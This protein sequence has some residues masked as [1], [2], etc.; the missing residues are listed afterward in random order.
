M[1][2]RT[3][4]LGLGS[5][6]I[7]RSAK[8]VVAPAPSQMQ[9]QRDGPKVPVAQPIGPP[10]AV[11]LAANE[12]VVLPTAQ[13]HRIYLGLGWNNPDNQ[14]SV[15]LDCSVVGFGADGTRDPESTVWFGK[16]R[17][18]IHQTQ[19]PGSS[20]V[21]TGDILTGSKSNLKQI[22]T[23]M[24]RI[25]VWLDAVP[26]HLTTIAF[27]AEVFTTGLTF[28]A[29]SSAYCRVVNADTGQEL[30]RLTLTSEHL[31]P[32]ADSRVMLLARLRRL[33]GADDAMWAL[34]STAE[35]RARV[36]R[37]ENAP[38][39]DMVTYSA[40]PLAAAAAPSEPL[41]AVLVAPIAVG[42]GLPP[43]AQTQQGA[44]AGPPVPPSKGRLGGRAWVCPALAVGSAAGV[45][46]ATAIFLTSDVSPL[47]REMLDDSLFSNGVDFAAGA[48]MPV[49]VSAA[50][51][52]FG[53]ELVAAGESA[54]QAATDAASATGEALASAG[55]GAADAAA[56]AGDA[57]H[58]AG[59][60][61]GEALHGMGEAVGEALTGAGEALTGAGEA[62]TGAIS[63]AGEA[64][65][66]AAENMS[67]V[68][69][70]ECCGAACG[71]FECGDCDCACEIG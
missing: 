69:N 36:L 68:C 56:G 59:Q 62:L 27:A 11:T 37:E 50:G 23:D 22:E 39:P 35:P 20:I 8:S 21:H 14:Q 54:G 1:N 55:E 43:T 47:S 64:V 24:E 41:K 33:G 38:Q 67:G 51:D 71:G 40:L 28:A 10:V 5:L 52:F 16:L 45:A 57:L 61:V 26:S 58:G 7:G 53:S 2:S 4:N 65:A 70:C 17:N 18:G 6:T 34:Q 19:K 32:M 29:L 60:A 63:G 48:C 49:D 25:Y 42:V 12:S 15:D 46:A 66:A 31:G 13:L 30:A 3:I 44:V 9:M